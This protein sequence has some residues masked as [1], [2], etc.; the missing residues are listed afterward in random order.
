MNRIRM[1]KVALVAAWLAGMLL[2]AG[3]SWWRSTAASVQTPPQ[4]KAQR[5]LPQKTEKAKPEDYV[6]TDT[7]ST[8]HEGTHKAFL[9]TPHS[10]LSE[11]S[12]WKGKVTGCES[13]HGP[14]REHVEAVSNGA[15]AAEGPSVIKIRSFRGESPKQI[16]ETCL[17]CH[18]GREEHNN[19]RRGEHWRNDVGCTECHSTHDQTPGPGRNLASSN[20]QVA[21]SNA[22]KP[23]FGNEKMLRLSEPQL[24]MKCHTETKHQFNMP[25]RHKV[26][27]GAM[28]CSDCHNAHGGFEQKQARLA[29]G[30]DQAC[31]KCHTD[32]QGPFTY[33]HAPVKTE[34]CASCHTPHGSANPRLLRTNKVAQ[35]CLECHTVDH[36]VGA[37]EPIGPAHNLNL[38]YADC[39]SCHVK[40]H[41]SH[42]SPVFMR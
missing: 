26:L 21:A 29:T 4:D 38:Q 15:T 28:R 33:E 16:S 35:L 41:G 9:K 1:L 2:L 42:T 30:A 36:G 20:V 18:S 32:K 3:G 10:K 19:F 17:T 8:C 40:I 11:E 23:G 39:T 37:L 14:G 22:E 27:E 24:C 34:G 31:I 5:E 6:G 25:F 7:C 12:S 13:C